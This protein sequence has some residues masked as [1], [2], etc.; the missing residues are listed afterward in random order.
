MDHVYFNTKTYAGALR[1]ANAG[2]EKRPATAAKETYYSSKR[3]L[4]LQQKRP[5]LGLFAH[6]VWQCISVSL[7]PPALCP[8]LRF[9]CVC[10]GVS[11]YVAQT[12]KKL[13]TRRPLALWQK[14][15][16]ARRA[17]VKHCWKR[18]KEGFATHLGCRRASLHQLNLAANGITS[19]AFAVF[20]HATVS[21]QWHAVHPGSSVLEGGKIMQQT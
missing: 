21:Y 10:W 5:S 13:A 6:C 3:D 19:G 18:E 15:H 2:Q 17:E 7:P 1:P 8:S 20:R 11:V 14:A 16:Q 12:P 9:K 4:P